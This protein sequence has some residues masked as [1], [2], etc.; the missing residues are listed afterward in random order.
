MLSACETGIGEVKNGEGVYGLRRAL[1][2]AGSESQVMSMWK[3]SDRA[4]RDLMVAYYKR[5][6]AGDGRTEALRQVQLEMLGAADLDE[7]ADRQGLTPA[8]KARRLTTATRSSGRPS[9]S[10]ATGEVWAG[11]QAHTSDHL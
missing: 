1:M 9:F 11:R 4:T 7:S 3:V 6:Q 5:L 8:H 2:L 10:R